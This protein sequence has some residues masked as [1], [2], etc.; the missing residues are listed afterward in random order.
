M[1]A[2][3]WVGMTGCRNEVPHANDIT[4]YVL[5]DQGLALRA[6]RAIVRFVG[7][8]ES[9]YNFTIL[10]LA[11]HEEIIA[12]VRATPHAFAIANAAQLL[13]INEASKPEAIIDTSHIRALFALYQNFLHVL[14]NPISLVDE[15]SPKFSAPII[16]YGQNIP[17]STRVHIGRV[18]RVADG[19][20]RAVRQAIDSAAITR[21]ETGELS[22]L[23]FF[24]TYPSPAI[25]MT[26]TPVNYTQLLP[27]TSTLAEDILQD[28]GY[29]STTTLPIKEYPYLINSIPVQT[30]SIPTVLITAAATDALLVREMCRAFNAHFEEYRTLYQQFEPLTR[31]TAQDSIGIPLH[32]QAEEC[33]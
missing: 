3:G 6:A 19:R 15:S 5:R 11:T 30:L 27:I 33:L 14:I 26:L 24:D 21:V 10:S 23:L 28:I 12:T 18:L 25:T 8:M 16:Y 1:G 4:I 9:A 31:R 20:A 2:L 7:A 29:L 17:A 22:A 13:Y 32:P